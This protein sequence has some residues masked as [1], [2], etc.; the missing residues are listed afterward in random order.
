M[1]YGRQHLQGTRFFA[2]VSPDN[3]GS[4]RVLEKA[5]LRYDRDFLLDE[6]THALFRTIDERK[7]RE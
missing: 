7:G 4:R 5:G 6:T 2:L 1:D 3:L